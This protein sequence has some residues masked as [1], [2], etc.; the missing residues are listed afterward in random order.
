M[1]SKIAFTLENRERIQAVESLFGPTGTVLA[2]P[3]RVLV[4]EGQL[5]K[6][7]R[8]RPQPKAF[9]LFN[10]VLVYGSI[11]VHGRWLKGQKII[12]LEHIQMEDLEDC[13]MMKNQWLIRTPRKSFY[14]AAASLQ[15]KRAWMEHIEDCRSSLLRSSDCRPGSTF[16]MAWIPDQ[17][18]ALCMRCTRVFSVTKR[19]HHCRNCGFLVCERCSKERV[20]LPHINPTK[21]LRVCR[22]CQQNLLQEKDNHDEA[23]QRGGSMEDEVP[24]EGENDGDSSERHTS[25]LWLHCPAETWTPYTYLKTA[26]CAKKS[27]PGSCIK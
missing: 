17:V 4:G 13:T 21:P 18:S 22:L 14:V 27:T 16:A 2:M 24:S 23:R 5:I 15:E 11:I 3:S 6:Q 26:H 12:P 9:F 1:A 19:R 25:K 7:C 10:D 8:R 20:L